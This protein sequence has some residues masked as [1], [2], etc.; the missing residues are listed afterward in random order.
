MDLDFPHLMLRHRAAD[1]QNE[2]TDFTQRQLAETDRNGSLA[3][4]ASPLVNWAP[5]NPIT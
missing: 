2:A 4:L 3:R 1:P 5:G